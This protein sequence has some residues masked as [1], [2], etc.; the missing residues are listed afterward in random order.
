MDPEILAKTLC[1]NCN[2]FD[3]CIQT[4][5]QPIFFCEEYDNH[6]NLM[7]TAIVDKELCFI[8]HEKV[9][10]HMNCDNRA[11]CIYKNGNPVKWFCEE[12]R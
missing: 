7:K 4:R 11:F 8:H 2:E 12:Y 6:M 5:I 10:L 3:T 1:V 9:D